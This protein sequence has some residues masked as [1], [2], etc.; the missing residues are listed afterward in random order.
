MDDDDNDDDDAVD[1]V[2]DDDIFA[3]MFSVQAYEKQRDVD[4]NFV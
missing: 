2:N 1:D 3:V 4:D